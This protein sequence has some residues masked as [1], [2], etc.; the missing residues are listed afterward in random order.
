MGLPIRLT[1][2]DE[3]S[4]RIDHSC[5]QRSPGRRLDARPHIAVTLRADFLMKSLDALHHH[6]NPRAGAAI[7]VMF[8]QVQYEIAAR[9]LP[10]EGSSGIKAMVPVD[11][12]A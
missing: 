2:A 4:E 11:R 8:A 7:A 5:L 9:Y 1:E 10:I 3:I 12:E 6:A